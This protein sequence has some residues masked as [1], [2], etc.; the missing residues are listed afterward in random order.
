MK[1]ES[2]NKSVLVFLAY[3]GHSVHICHMNEQL[4][5]EAHGRGYEP[6]NNDSTLCVRHDFKCNSFHLDDIVTTFTVAVI[7]SLLQMRQNEV[8]H[9]KWY[10]E[11]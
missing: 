2:L 9:P 8:K 6:A 5:R 10:L 1:L 11:D 4:T 7:T 3:N